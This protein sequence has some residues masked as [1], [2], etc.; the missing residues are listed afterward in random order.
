MKDASNAEIA[1]VLPGSKSVPHQRDVIPMKAETA[2]RCQLPL[3]VSPVRSHDAGAVSLADQQM[4]EFMCDPESQN[5]AAGLL[6]IGGREAGQELLHF[7]I[8]NI[9]ARIRTCASGSDSHRVHTGSPTR[10]RLW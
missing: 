4:S 6:F 1:S 2:P 3:L 10:R 5:E 9:R 7:V 8:E